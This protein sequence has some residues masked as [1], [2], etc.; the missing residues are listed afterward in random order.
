MMRRRF[1]TR[2]FVACLPEGA[3]AVHDGV[4]ADTSEWMS[5]QAAI[6][7]Y[8]SGQITLAPPQIMTLAVLHHFKDFTALRTHL[9]GHQAPLIEPFP[10][11]DDT[12]ARSIAYPGDPVHPVQ[13][14]A[15]PGPSRLVWR[16]DHF[17][18]PEGPAA[19]FKGA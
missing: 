17:E 5:P 14:A 2:F 15:F 9:Q 16:G 4:E 3:S 8:C 7:A 1:D 6:D 18:P 12:G 19:Y 10:F 11:K 13:M